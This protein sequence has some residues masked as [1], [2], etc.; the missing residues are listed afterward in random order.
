MYTHNCNTIGVEMKYVSAFTSGTQQKINNMEN[1]L[2]CF[3]GIDKHNLIPL[4][5]NVHTKTQNT[6]YKEE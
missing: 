2:F 5:P 6:C 4:N 1:I 3:I